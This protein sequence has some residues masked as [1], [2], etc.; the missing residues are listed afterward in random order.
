[1]SMQIEHP[2]AGRGIVYTGESSEEKAGAESLPI[3]S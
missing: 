2:M 1:M 3:G